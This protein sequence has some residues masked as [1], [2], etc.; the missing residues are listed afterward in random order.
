MILGWTIAIAALPN[1]E[2]AAKLLNH[3]KIEYFDSTQIHIFSHFN[4]IYFP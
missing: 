2:P 1:Y 4:M 3:A